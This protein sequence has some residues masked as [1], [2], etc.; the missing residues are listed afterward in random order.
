MQEHAKGKTPRALRSVHTCEQPAAEN[1]SSHLEIQV[2]LSFLMVEL[3]QIPQRKQVMFFFLYY[4]N[5]KCVT[6]PLLKW[7]QES[8]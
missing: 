3:C 8:G 6:Y 5:S 1:M 7:S 2:T 4:S